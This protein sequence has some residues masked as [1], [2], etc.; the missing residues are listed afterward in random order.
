MTTAQ[1]MRNMQKIESSAVLPK[2]DS[3][4][5]DIK[6]VMNGDNLVSNTRKQGSQ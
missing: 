4:D 2:R 6:M 3:F 1:I 5:E